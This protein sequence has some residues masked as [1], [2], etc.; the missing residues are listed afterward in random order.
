MLQWFFILNVNVV[1][2]GCVMY[3][4][5]VLLCGYTPFQEHSCGQNCG[6]NRGLKCDACQVS[7]E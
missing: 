5:Y 4:R 7:A 3:R 1:L 2:F 6:W